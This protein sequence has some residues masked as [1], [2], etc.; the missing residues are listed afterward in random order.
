[1]AKFKLDE[2]MLVRIGE[3]VITAAL[4]CLC[5][6]TCQNQKEGVKTREMSIE[7]RK[8]IQKV[9]QKVDGNNEITTKKIDALRDAQSKIVNQITELNDA[10]AAF[11]DSLAVT[12]GKLNKLDSV[13]RAQKPCL[14]NPTKGNTKPE[15]PAKPVQPAKP[16]KSQPAK[17]VQ[18]AQPVK[19]VV[20]AAQDTVV[21][22]SSGNMIV[23]SGAAQSQINGN[24]EVNF[25]NGINNGTVIIN[26]G[27]VINQ[28]GIK[29]SQPQDSVTAVIVATQTVRKYVYRC[30]L[31]R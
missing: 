15:K 21:V 4:I 28:T 9:D 16:V 8:E 13:Q 5:V 20:V 29:Q 27:G 11:F 30:G 25:E 18:P 22:P 24:T 7:N 23:N 10:D 1:M 2:K 17:P 6:A 26:N 31:R 12:N 14:C 3:G 19:P